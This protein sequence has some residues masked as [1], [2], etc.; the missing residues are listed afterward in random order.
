MKMY[1]FRIADLSFNLISPVELQIPTNFQAFLCPE[2]PDREADISV[3][4]CFENKGIPKN[5]RKITETRYQYEDIIQDF[6]FGRDGKY[7]VRTQMMDKPG[8]YRLSIPI[9]FYESFCKNSNWLLYLMMERMILP[10]DRLILHA[11]AVIYGG[12]AYLFSA[13]SG[14]GKSTHA[15]LW[16]KHYGATLLN[17]D[18]VILERGEMGWIAHGSPIAGSS[19][20]YCNKSAP[21]AAIIMLE[22]APNNEITQISGRNALLQLYSE[23]VKSNWDENFNQRV[24]ELIFSLL[25]QCRVFRL[26]CLP[27]TSAVDCVLRELEGMTS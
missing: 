10:F 27:Q 16:V 25:E 26:K 19:G 6:F 18:K 21:I 15:A 22:K 20:V 13:H 3:E 14:G 4:V 17:G 8:V 24:L 5:A 23:A 2:F 9:S 7:I 11:S 1:H 12:K